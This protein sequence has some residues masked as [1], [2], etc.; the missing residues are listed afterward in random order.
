M[1]SPILDRQALLQLLQMKS[2]LGS[3]GTDAALRRLRSLLSP[4]L[5]LLSAVTASLQWLW[6]AAATSQSAGLILPAFRSC[7]QTSLKRRLGRPAGLVPVASSLFSMSLGIPS[8]SMRLTWPSQRSQLWLS[9]ANT[10]GTSDC[11]RTSLFGTRSCQVMP[12]MLLRQH[13]WRCC[14]CVLGGSRG[15]RSCYPQQAAEHAGLVQLHLGADGQLGIVPDPPE[16]VPV[17]QFSV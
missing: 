12:K 16:H 2:M 9:K 6:S 7:L 5:T 1:Y 8:S 14:V 4:F 15:S 17:F 11:A 10:Q 3:E 13:T